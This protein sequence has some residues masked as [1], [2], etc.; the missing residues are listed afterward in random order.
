MQNMPNDNTPKLLSV[1]ALSKSYSAHQVL[2]DINFDIYANTCVLLLGANGAGKSTLLKICAGLAQPDSGKVVLNEASE[3]SGSLGFQG[4]Q[5]MLY[6]H[7]T[8]EENLLLVSK[9]VS[10][11]FGIDDILSEWDLSGHRNKQIHQLSRGLQFRVSLAATLASNPKFIILDEPSSSFD[12]RTLELMHIKVKKLVVDG[13]ALIATHDIERS[14]MIADRV[15]VLNE[16][17]IAFDSL[18]Q[19]RGD[20]LTATIEKAIS[21]Y[22]SCN[23]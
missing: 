1:Q 14:K 4:H 15:L 18:P 9:A 11:K 16:A 10:E 21:F 22:R 19:S 5:L 13:F 2:K 3:K 8:V 7:L 17:K 6:S 20:N 23:R 12:D